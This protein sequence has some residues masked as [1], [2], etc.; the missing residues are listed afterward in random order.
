MGR[1]K[2]CSFFFASP[3]KEHSGSSIVSSH[4]SVILFRR[5]DGK[6]LRENTER[7]NNNNLTIEFI[8]KQKRFQGRFK[9]N[10]ET[11]IM[12]NSSKFCSL[13]GNLCTLDMKVTH[14]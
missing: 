9:R 7:K 10:M 6:D 3:E 13:R 4:F 11:Y 14:R 5:H 12:S 2:I 1:P 8:Y